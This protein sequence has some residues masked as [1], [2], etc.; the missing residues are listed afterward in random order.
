M[1][2]FSE[3]SNWQEIYFARVEAITINGKT[4]V[5]PLLVQ[6]PFASPYFR[7]FVEP[8]NDP[9]SVNWFRG[10]W[11][12]LFSGNVTQFGGFI[13]S[14]IDFKSVL[15]GEWKILEFPLVNST[16]FFIRYEAPPW[17]PHVRVLIQQYQESGD[18]LLSEDE[19]PLPP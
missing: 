4:R 18:I 9:R 5:Q 14:A 6:I 1:V 10:G 17:F 11:F 13:P 19:P 7:I 8:P 12:K 2:D 15:L 3:L 16:Q